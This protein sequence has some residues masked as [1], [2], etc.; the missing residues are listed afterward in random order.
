MRNFAFGFLLAGAGFV[1]CSG[2]VVIVEDDGV[3]E[4]GT[5]TPGTN[6]GGF[7]EGPGPEGA[8]PPSPESSGGAGPVVAGVGG[9]G[10]FEV[11]Q[12]ECGIACDVLFQCGLQPASSGGALCVGLEPGDQEAFS[13]FCVPAC[14]DV[15]AAVGFI[16]GND[17]DGT[18]STLSSLSIEFD[19]LC[20]FG[21]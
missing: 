19:Q 9:G 21:F 7:G 17:C 11:P 5:H 8:S 20:D 10:G 2:S 12:T 15:P 6:E 13:N 3:A 14:N 18:V 1:G 4:G 16:D